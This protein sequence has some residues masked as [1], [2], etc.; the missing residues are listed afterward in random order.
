MN[1]SGRPPSPPPSLPALHSSLNPP[2]VRPAAGDQ[3][4]SPL[5]ASPGATPAFSLQ[6]NSGVASLALPHFFFFAK[7]RQTAEE[8]QR[9]RQEGAQT[10]RVTTGRDVLCRRRCA[11]ALCAACR[12]L[13]VEAGRKG[14]NGSLPLTMSCHRLRSDGS[15][16]PCGSERRVAIYTG[17]TGFNSQGLCPAEFCSS[18]FYFKHFSIHFFFPL[19]DC[20]CF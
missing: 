19:H 5:L 7:D 4:R 20:Y 16:D 13:G 8:R 3:R 9:A 14:G 2:C 15:G 12:A 6:E 11:D 17:F 18:F 1:T 10:G